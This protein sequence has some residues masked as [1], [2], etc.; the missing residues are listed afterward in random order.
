M[1]LLEI[2]KKLKESQHYD[3]A[4][5]LLKVHDPEVENYPDA[6]YSVKMEIMH[7]LFLQAC[8]NAPF[9]ITLER[10][11]KKKKKKTLI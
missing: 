4:V 6:S 1:Q 9:L 8:I 3:L 10:E 5:K 7:M 11:Q 2:A